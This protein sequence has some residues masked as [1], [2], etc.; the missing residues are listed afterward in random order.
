MRVTS[1]VKP[2]HINFIE[3]N[4]KNILEKEK[5]GR[6]DNCLL[7]FEELPCERKIT[8]SVKPPMLAV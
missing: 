8:L 2:C 7:I 5:L 1:V 4:E 6:C 3:Q